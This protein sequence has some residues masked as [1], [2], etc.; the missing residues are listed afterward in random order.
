MVE[1]AVGT[2][3][4]NGFQP[5]NYDVVDYSLALLFILG[6]A[7]DDNRLTCFVAHHVAVLLHQIK[8]KAFDIQHNTIRAGK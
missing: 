8:N 5:V 2:K 6:A 1:V 7:V 3:Q 4:V